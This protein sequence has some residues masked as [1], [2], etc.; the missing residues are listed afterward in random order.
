MRGWK[1]YTP[2]GLIGYRVLVF[3]HVGPLEKVAR[4]AILDGCCM[5]A[6]LG[7]AALGTVLLACAFEALFGCSPSNFAGCSNWLFVPISGVPEHHILP[8]VAWHGR[9]MVLAWA[10]L[11]PAAFVVAR[12]YKIT[13]GQDWPRRLDNPFWFVT[14]RRLGYVIAIL[15]IAALGFVIWGRGGLILWQN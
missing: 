3:Q 10:I 11:M 1:C 8:S 15:T 2:A 13:P 12:F 9:L 7:V 6:I 4:A 5:R 14:H